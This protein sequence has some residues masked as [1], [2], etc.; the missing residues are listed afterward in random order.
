VSFPARETDTLK[1]LSA[2]FYNLSHCSHPVILEPSHDE[3]LY[4]NGQQPG[5]TALLS[6]SDFNRLAVGNEVAWQAV[7]CSYPHAT[8]AAELMVVDEAAAAS[9]VSAKVAAARIT[10][11]RRTVARMNMYAPACAGTRAVGCA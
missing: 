2:A 5:S 1:L 6:A 8:H 4:A 7:M 9:V 3:P 11:S 10:I